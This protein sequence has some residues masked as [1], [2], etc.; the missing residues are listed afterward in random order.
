VQDELGKIDLNASDEGSLASLFA[1]AGLSSSVAYSLADKILDWRSRNALRSLN[2]ATESDYRTLG[3]LYH[4]RGGPFL[5][6]DELRL[7]MGV[8]PEI[9]AQV[10]AALTV[11]SGRPLINPQ[12]APRAVL[13]A[14]PS[15]DEGTVN[16]LLVARADDQE[17]G[18]VNSAVIDPA[19]VLG[20]RAFAVAA[21]FG[22]RDYHVSREAVIRLTGDTT[23][24]YWILASR[25]R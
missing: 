19:V 23:E 2:G 8:T 15:A 25:R 18:A 22:D 9:F 12:T 10:K 13:L 11:Y 21:E 24:P 3:Y 16:S 17:G 14:M 4:P 6:I 1:S 5:T 7:V 20:G